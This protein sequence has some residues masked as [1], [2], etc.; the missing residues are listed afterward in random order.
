MR[1]TTATSAAARS[2]GAHAPPAPPPGSA[3]AGS[4]C[5]AAAA[6][7]VGSRGEAS[8]RCKHASLARALTRAAR[9]P[10]TVMTAGHCVAD[11]PSNELVE[12]RVRLGVI[13]QL[14]RSD[15]Y[16][17]I[18]ARARALCVSDRRT[19]T[20]PR[21]AAN[22]AASQA[23][24]WQ[25]HSAYNPAT[26]QNDIALI[27][28]QSPA[29]Y[30]PAALDWGDRGASDVGTA[31]A[32]VG[33]GLTWPQY[34]STSTDYASSSL[35]STLLRVKLGITDGG[36]YARQCCSRTRVCAAAPRR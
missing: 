34:S 19:L 32:V 23:A 3:R 11:E 29:T 18:M 20:A 30:A 1:T 5:A 33:F 15:D 12:V 26:L 25:T 22:A 16:Q 35:S 9:S 31:V 17:Q 27:F 6:A 4:G 21:R 8:R 13:N 24:D 10:T 7:A 14:N 28:L 2:S 36:W